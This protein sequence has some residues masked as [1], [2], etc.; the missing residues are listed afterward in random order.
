M[1]KCPL[2]LLHDCKKVCEY[3]NTFRRINKE[4]A[5][6]DDC[7]SGLHWRM[8]TLLETVSISVF[9][10]W[11]DTLIHW[12]YLNGPRAIFIRRAYR[13]PKMPIKRS[14]CRRSSWQSSSSG[15]EIKP[16]DLLMRHIGWERNIKLWLW[17]LR[18]HCFNLS[19]NQNTAPDDD[20]DPCR[21]PALKIT[22]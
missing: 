6:F 11:Y 7:R 17:P 20:D 4:E 18:R 22:N 2:I 14:D 1:T 5:M 15:S 10:L 8:S 19:R 12:Q 3:I 13:A 16:I 21:Q 9:L